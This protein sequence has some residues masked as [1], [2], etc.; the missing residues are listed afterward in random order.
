MEAQTVRLWLDTLADDDAVF[1]DDGG[2]TLRSEK[3]PDAYLE[4]GGQSLPCDPDCTCPDCITAHA[5]RL[6]DCCIREH[7][8]A[9]PPWTCRCA[10]HGARLTEPKPKR[11]E[12]CG[13]G[14]SD[15]REVEGEQ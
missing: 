14:Q 12:G 8:N 4:I 2:L 9:V 6:G 1:I 13:C 5:A 7:A 3:E 10:C 11:Y 15:C